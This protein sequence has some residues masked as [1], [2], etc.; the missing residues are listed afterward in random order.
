MSRWLPPPRWHLRHA[1]TDAANRT[2]AVVGTSGPAATAPPAE[3]NRLGVER[4]RGALLNGGVGGAAEELVTPMWRRVI[5]TTT[6][7]CDPGVGTSVSAKALPVGG[8]TSTS[9]NR[10]G[11]VAR[12]SHF[13]NG[14]NIPQ[15]GNCAFGESGLTFQATG[16]GVGASSSKT[17]AS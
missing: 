1:L 12:T 15:W 2:A 13:P 10:I 3:R 16:E 11:S 9:H 17:R 4:A 8:K 6:V 7:K 14:V 5:K